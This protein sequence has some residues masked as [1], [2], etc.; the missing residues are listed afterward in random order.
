MMSDSTK[1]ITYKKQTL[2]VTGK[3]VN[4][5]MCIIRIEEKNLPNRLTPSRFLITIS[6][7]WIRRYRSEGHQLSKFSA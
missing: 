2:P 6:L 5:V 1:D 7:L 4:Q 3:G